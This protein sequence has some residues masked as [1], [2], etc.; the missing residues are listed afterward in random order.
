MAASRSNVGLMD[1]DDESLEGSDDEDDYS[2]NEP[3]DN[4]IV[5]FDMK[6]LDFNVTIC[7]YRQISC[8]AQTLQLVVHHFDE[9]TTFKDLLF[10]IS[11]W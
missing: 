2:D 10:R 9:V 5:D 4:D 8:F 7:S 3:S 6:E 11:F 1:D